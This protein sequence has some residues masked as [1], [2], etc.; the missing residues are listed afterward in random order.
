MNMPERARLAEMARQID[1]VAGVATI[2]P[3]AKQVEPPGY[4]VPQRD[5]IASIVDGVVRDVIE[6]IKALQ[7]ELAKLEDQ[8][9][10]SAAAAKDA[11]N[12][13]VEVC[14]RVREQT[15]SIRGTVD[16]IAQTVL[17]I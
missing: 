7:A 16:Q 3:P 14:S 12:K 8:V 1:Q 10:V 6:N 13:Q 15:D 5:A 2:S 17:R 11:L 9:L 4:G